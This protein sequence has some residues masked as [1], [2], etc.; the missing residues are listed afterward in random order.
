MRRVRRRDNL[1]FAE[2]LPL[3]SRRSFLAAT[4]SLVAT[5]SALTAA[6]AAP[7]PVP[8]AV[9]HFDRSIFEA[10][11]SQP[12][13]HKQIFSSWNLAGGQA[14]HW[15]RN[16]LNAYQFTMGEGPGTLQVAVVFYS[17]GGV[18]SV[19]D[20]Y[21]WR[22][23]RLADM[24]KTVFHDHVERTPGQFPHAATANPY[25][26]A[27]SNLDLSATSTT[28]GSIYADESMEAL[29]KQGA[30]FFA[31]NNTIVQYATLL[32]AGPSAAGRDAEQIRN[33]LL[34]HMLPGTML[35]PAGVAALVAAQEAKFTYAPA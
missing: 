20:D 8:P 22:T 18:A 23:Y 6:D 14:F 9:S 31:C 25:A 10:R 2:V 34:A 3:S 28:P 5:A 1:H 13:R 26:H 33:D 17:G 21:A 27:R 4:G 11:L 19:F 24:V 12:Y 35:V 7:G 29:A 15:M 32:A 16:S 30:T